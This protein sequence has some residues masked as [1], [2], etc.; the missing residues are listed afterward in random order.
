MKRRLF[1]TFNR[2]ALD[3][4]V[5]ST[6]TS[7]YGLVFNIFGATVNEETQTVA[8]ELEGTAAALDQAVTYL[9]ACGVRWE[10]APGGDGA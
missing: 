4:P 9:D 2:A 7:R 1:L 8:L 5:L 10:E 3:T 6:L